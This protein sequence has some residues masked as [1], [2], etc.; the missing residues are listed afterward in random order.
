MGALKARWAEAGLTDITSR[1]V[2]VSRS[3]ENFKEFRSTSDLRSP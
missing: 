3:F 1:G 2:G